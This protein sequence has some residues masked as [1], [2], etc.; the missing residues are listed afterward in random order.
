MTH[1]AIRQWADEVRPRYL[2]ANRA[3][4]RRIL[5]EFC[6]TTHY[7]RKAVIRLFRRVPSDAAPKRAGRHPIYHTAEI[8]SAL[9][10]V[11]EASGCVCGKYLVAGMA[12]L[13]DRL[14][15][16]GELLLSSDLRTKLL[17]MS[18]A[19]ADRLL[20]PHR[21][22][23]PTGKYGSSRL[24]SDL[25]RKIEM[26]TFAELRGLGVGQLEV[27]LVLHCGMTT[28]EFHLTSLVAVDTHT[29][30]TECV[31][32][33]GKGKTRV[34]SG[35]AR[36]LRAVPF[37]VFGVHSDNG[38][39]FINDTLYAFLQQ[40]GVHFGH[41]RA[42]H[43]ND[44]PR[45]EQRNGSLVRRLVGYGRFASH[46]AYE[47]LEQVYALA[48]MHANCFRPT[49]KL[50]ACERRNGK[51]IK[52]YDA[53]QTPYRRLLASGQLD[54]DT[55]LRLENEY[56]QL[57]PLQ[58][59]RELRGAID[60]LWKVEAVDPASERAQRLRKAAADAARK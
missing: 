12:D 1:D 17:G 15:A 47:R 11:W 51:V 25:S 42:Y 33:W 2:V 58:M 21:P 41:G 55:R 30:W 6:A 24:V 27:D 9:L 44:Q 39:E 50:L 59:Q 16:C 36:V 14:E 57:N 13:L 34:T 22:K 43:K 54:P 5:D 7:H 26:Q 48:C 31:P 28:S 45:V 18:A 52:R 49:A 60:S 3:G 4:K 20:R 8:V 10:L 46:A 35:M 37:K 32:V 38:S 53:P 40:Q 29:S 56:S 19:T 23:R